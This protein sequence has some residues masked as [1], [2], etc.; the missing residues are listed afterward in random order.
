[1]HTTA[2]FFWKY[3]E[4]SVQFNKIAISHTTIIRESSSF[5]RIPF[6]SETLSKI[7]LELDV[8]GDWTVLDFRDYFFQGNGYKFKF[9]PDDGSSA[10]SKW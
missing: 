10:N 4:D 3:P 5:L 6:F 9:T 7:I 8:C 1:M 2:L